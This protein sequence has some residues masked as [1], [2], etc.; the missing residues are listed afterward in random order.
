[1]GVLGGLI[2]KPVGGVPTNGL[3]A[4]WL[5]SNN[6]LDT[7]G[8]GHNGTPTG[9]TFGNNRHGTPNSALVLNGTSDFVDVGSGLAIGTNIRSFSFWV[10]SSSA[11]IQSVIG[12][13]N[14]NTNGYIIQSLVPGIHFFNTTNNRRFDNVSEYTTGDWIHVVMVRKGTPNLIYKNNVSAGVTLDTE[15]LENPNSSLNTRIGVQ[16]LNPDAR[17]FNGSLDDMRIYN[18]VLTVGEIDALFNE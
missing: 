4:E 18:R 10:K 5:F 11:T 2:L 9:T 15:S 12:T 16:Y 1:M 3:L 13:R 7:S 6:H 8:N 14:V 17:F